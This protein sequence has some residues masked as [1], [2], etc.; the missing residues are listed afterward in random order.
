MENVAAEKVANA[1]KLAE[2]KE[3]KLEV[4]RLPAINDDIQGDEK[5]YKL[6][7]VLGEGGYGTVFLS[8]DG[9]RSVAV[10]TEKFSKSM[11]HIDVGVLKAAKAA[12]ARHFCELIDYG[13][14]KPDYVYMVM[15]LL[16]K[17]LHKLRN[18]MPDK[19]FTISTSLRVSMQSLKAIEELHKLGYISRDIKPGNF[20]PGHRCNRQSK[21]I[22]LYD[23]G[24]SKR[25]ID[26]DLGRRDDLES[27]FYM[28]VEMTRGTLPWRFV[29]ERNAVGSAKQAAR[30]AGRKQFLYETPKQFDRILTMVD[31]YSFESQPE[32]EK[33]YK[34]LEEV[35][36]L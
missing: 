17:D 26:K 6:K 33:I 4:D 5:K 36:F 7:K 10:K 31:S 8:Q 13:S 32:Y 1:S 9:E 2:Q 14:N 3:K 15:T 27:W 25:Y 16:Y 30:G 11:L 12:K 24:L 29:S 23:F 22:F 19:R 34:T 28:I 35:R 21:I 18:E 20:A